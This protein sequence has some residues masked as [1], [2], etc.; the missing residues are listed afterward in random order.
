MVICNNICITVLVLSDT[1][2]IANSAEITPAEC[3]WTLELSEP[4]LDSLC[5]DVRVTDSIT[6]APPLRGIR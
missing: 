2:T 1:V 5:I 6:S 4:F 3:Y